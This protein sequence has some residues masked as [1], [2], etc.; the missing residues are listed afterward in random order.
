M[1]ARPS[2]LGTLVAALLTAAPAA[3]D[4]V[5]P[6]GS[7]IG[8]EPAP[9]LAAAKSFQGFEDAAGLA[10]VIVV[11]LPP[12][13]FGALETA[14][15]A[16]ISEAGKAGSGKSPAGAAN[17]GKAKAAKS[18]K[19]PAPEEVA[20]PAGRAYFNRE[21]AESSDRGK[22][23][24]LVADA[25]EFTAYVM[26]EIA[27]DAEKDFPEDVIRKMLTSVS[28]RAA[29]P[30]AEQLD[31]LPFRLGEL[32]GF[33]NIK[34]VIPGS[35]VVL[36]DGDDNTPVEET[37]YMVISV[38]PGTAPP[39]EGRARFAEHLLTTIPGLR[40]TRITSS[41]PIRIG[42]APGIETRIEAVS[43]KAD[44]EVALIQ[45]VRFGPG[46][47][48]RIVAGTAKENWTEAFPRF[49]TVRDRIEPR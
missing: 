29:V 38:A 8:L 37:T 6:P 49:R 41:E 28:I 40:N 42:G 2:I 15:K 46:A 43:G 20:T 4:P 32:A 31:M 9:G 7:R 3:A 33:K 19:P 36:S 10:K 11:Q 16:R 26:A 48:L 24:A 34:S 23:W 35:T 39:T 30:V 44:K 27:P 14:A 17:K 22:R 13:A 25:G 47:Y 12:A 45:W 21:P 5:F 18:E 1:N